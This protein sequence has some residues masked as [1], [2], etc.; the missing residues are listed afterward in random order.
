[1]F[2]NYFADDERTSPIN[3]A[4]ARAI[5][6]IWLIWKTV[7]YD[8][9]LFVE[10]PFHQT[11]EFA[12]AVPPVAPGLILT[13]EKWILIGLLIGFVL[14]YRIQ[15][16]AGVS[17]F[18]LAHLGTVRA[19]QLTSGETESLFIGVYFLIFFALFSET[20]VLSVDSLRR[21]K[22]ESLDTLRSRLES[23]AASYRMP[24]L[25]WS[26]VVIALIYFGSGFDKIFH[27]GILNPTL[28]FATSENIARITTSYRSDG[29][30]QFVTENSILM[31]MGGIG[32]LVL[33]LGFLI[34]VLVGIT[35]TPVIVGLFGFTVSNVLLL[36][37]HFV[38]VYVILLLFAAWDLGY[39]R[40]VRVRQID[41]VFDERCQFCMRSLVPFAILDIN[42]TVTF[43]PQSE[44]PDRYSQR[45]DVDF[46]RA[47]YV[48][49]NGNSYEGYYAFREL[50]RQYRCFFPVVWFMGL[51]FVEDFGNRIYRYVA[52]NRGTKFTCRVE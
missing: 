14:G 39:E 25:K 2:V 48:F 46:E 10:V 51:S 8:W 3:L 27:S 50:L 35:I 41:V 47:M 44:A 18:L 52:E 7:M 17:A 15:F 9:R 23:G 11:P 13:V 34:A 45:N 38:D 21:T 29:P 19:T 32:T 12:W 30:L 26:L 28:E 5:L 22:H 49:H 1:M 33:E 20:D 36:G 24:A 37:I 31:R 40:I 4:I 6:G 16:T 43:L 42:N